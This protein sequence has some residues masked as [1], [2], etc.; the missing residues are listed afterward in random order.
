MR[1][2]EPCMRCG[3]MYEVTAHQATSGLSN[4][5]ACSRNDPTLAAALTL[6]AGC[7][8]SVSESEPSMSS[9]TQPLLAPSS[10]ALS[11]AP[12]LSLMESCDI[13]SCIEHFHRLSMISNC[14]L[15]YH[16]NRHR[17]TTGSMT[18]H[19]I[20]AHQCQYQGQHLDLRCDSNLCQH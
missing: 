9:V 12:S 11:A 3:L 13:P 4:G 1:A 17:A 2:V 15:V 6:M 16:G 10:E 5:W 19:S 20:T 8:A 14:S 18:L 7:S